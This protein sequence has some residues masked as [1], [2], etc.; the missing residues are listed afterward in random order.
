MLQATPPASRGSFWAQH[1]ACL[2]DMGSRWKAAGINL[3]DSWECAQEGNRTV[4]R[5]MLLQ[6]FPVLGRARQPGNASR[7][8][9]NLPR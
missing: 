5:S 8:V 2:L 6:D 1:Q 9:S 3:L 4:L 7:R